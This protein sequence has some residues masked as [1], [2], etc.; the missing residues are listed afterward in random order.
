[1]SII[2]FLKVTLVTLLLLL[3]FVGGV[4]V[5]NFYNFN[6]YLCPVKAEPYILEQDFISKNGIVIPKGT[7]IPLR[8]CA[9]MQRF[10]YKFAIDNA[11][12]LK[13]HVDKLDGNY[14]FSELFPK[15]EPE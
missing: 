5:G 4:V 14:G 11:T 7:V 13:Q 3:I 1:M 12:E 8:Q 6:D 9:Y 15:R 10:S 2:K